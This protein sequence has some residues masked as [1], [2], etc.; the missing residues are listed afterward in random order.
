MATDQVPKEELMIKE[1]DELREQLAASGRATLEAHAASSDAL[2]KKLDDAMQFTGMP[3][4]W[5]M[6][7]QTRTEM[8]ATGVRSPL[9]VQVLGPDVKV[10][11]EGS[12]LAYKAPTTGAYADA[13]TAI[14]DDLRLNLNATLSGRTP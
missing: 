14:G 1:I 9:G 8:L 2:V 7:I 11:D 13:V 10:I 5:W 4:V 3:N 12:M 6:P